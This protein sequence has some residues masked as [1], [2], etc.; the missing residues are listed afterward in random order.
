MIIEAFG[1]AQIIQ[2]GSMLRF[3][4]NFGGPN[5][6]VVYKQFEVTDQRS[7]PHN[8]VFYGA[9]IVYR[10]DQSSILSKRTYIESVTTVNLETGSSK[11]FDP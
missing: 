10:C 8:T 6:E 11:S 5:K 7:E 1:L 2:N 9:Q 4:K 3:S